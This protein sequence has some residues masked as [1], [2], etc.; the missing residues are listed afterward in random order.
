MPLPLTGQDFRNLPQQ[1]PA[2]P[3]LR[4]RGRLDRHAHRCQAFEELRGLV[5]FDS[6]EP[7]REVVRRR[8]AE[9]GQKVPGGD[10]AAGQ[11]LGPGELGQLLALGHLRGRRRLQTRFHQ[12]DLGRSPDA[13]RVLEFR[14]Q[15]ADETPLLLLGALVVEGDQALEDLLVGQGLRPA[16]GLEDSGVEVVVDLFLTWLRSSIRMIPAMKAGLAQ[17]PWR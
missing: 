15:P 4:A 14:T 9:L 5:G 11:V 8:L 6:L 7:L 10:H 13:L 3:C 2:P 1:A 16:V 12:R 17:K